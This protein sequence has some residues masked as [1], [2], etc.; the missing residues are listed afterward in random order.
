MI[1]LS[2]LSVWI[3]GEEGDIVTESSTQALIFAS[4]VLV[5]GTMLL[6]PLIADLALV[7]DVSEAYAGLIIIGYTVATSLT[8]P[9]AGMFTDTI[10]RR[11][12][13]VGGLTL[14][15]VAGAA[16]GTVPWFEAIVALRVLQGVGYAFAMP[17]ILTLFGDLYDGSTEATAQGIRVSVNSMMNSG[18]PLIAGVLFVYSWRYPFAVYLLGLV[19]AAWVWR[20]VPSTGVDT[21]GSLRGY[22]RD[23][24][25]FIRERQIALLMASFFFRFVVIYGLI[26]YISVLA[27]REVGLAV[28]AVGVLLAVNGG[29]KTVA[30]T[31]VGRLFPVFGS[32]LL[33]LL[34]FAAIVVGTVLMGSMPTVVALTA[35]VVIWG[36]GDGVLA[37]CQK[38]LLNQHSPPEY[39]G[40]AMSAALTFQNV[41]K[42]VGP[43]CLGLLLSV[44]GPG[45]AFVVLGV[46][47]GGLGIVSLALVWLLE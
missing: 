37:P 21:G 19:A 23:I 40:G 4:S 15:G 10:G 8:L 12:V 33:S 39:R 17:V 47:A 41:G 32:A 3:F 24:A 16:A 18:A 42:V 13:L 29:V 14:F 20:T 6:S 28:V 31:Q 5:M 30:S 25:G 26:T 45:P 11:R 34:S 22:V 9:I 36:I 46:V 7:F 43:G 44:I 1:G 35:G 38:S 2:K 27:I